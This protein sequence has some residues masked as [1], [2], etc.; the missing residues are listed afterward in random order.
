MIPAVDGVFSFP[1]NGFISHLIVL[2]TSSISCSSFPHEA[3][4]VLSFS[5]TDS[6]SEDE[7]LLGMG[8]G[9]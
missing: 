5:R 9:V 4:S 1:P 3:H 8:V 7:R 2:S 6:L